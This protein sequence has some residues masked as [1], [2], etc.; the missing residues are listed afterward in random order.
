MEKVA[1]ITGAGTGIGRSAAVCL[2][3]EGFSVVL[4]GRRREPLDATAEMMTSVRT[5]VVPTDVARPRLGQGAVR[6]DQG[7]VRPPRPAVQQRRHRRA[8]RCRSKT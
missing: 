5:L 2:G 3:K 8:A 4:A 7:D 1:L 6:Q